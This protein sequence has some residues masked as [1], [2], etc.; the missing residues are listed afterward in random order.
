M[1]HIAVADSQSPGQT[2]TYKETPSESVHSPVHNSTNS[3]MHDKKLPTS[4]H[5][6][7]TK[8]KIGAITDTSAIKHTRRQPKTKKNFLKYKLKDKKNSKD[9]WDTAKEILGWK[10]TAPPTIIMD[11]GKAITSPKQI[12]DI[13]NLKMLEKVSQTIARIPKSEIDP[14]LNLVN[15]C[16]SSN[17]YPASL[18]QSR[19]IRLL[20]V[21]QPPKPPTNPTSYTG[22]NLLMSFGKIIDKIV[23]KQLLQ[24]LIENT[25][26]HNAHHR[27]IQG[28][29]TTTAVVTLMYIW[30]ELIEDEKK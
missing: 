30:A 24:Y 14:I 13:L 16:I 4:W 1:F 21:S 19:V 15:S 10:K 2:S 17:Q 18:K 3:W 11:K 20:K 12:A 28:R 8:L 6:R 26:I 27:S 29:S 25:L 7:L 22:I 5:K 23:L 9:K